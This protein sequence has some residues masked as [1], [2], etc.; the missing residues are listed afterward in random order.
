M[1][2]SVLFLFLLLSTGIAF[3]QTTITLQDQCNC[4]VLSGT[5]VSS[6]GALVPSGADT[7]DIYVNTNTGTIYFWDGNSWELTATDDQQLTGF[8][9]N[10]ATN[11]LTLT[12]EDGGSVNVD[13]SS[14]SDSLIDTNTT[15]AS[16]GIDGANTNLVITDSDTNTYAVALADIAALIDTDDQTLSEVLSEGNS[17][18]TSI[19]NVTDP[20]NA[21]DA[22]TKNY[23]D[24][25]ITANEADGSETIVNGGT[26]I[27]V[28]GSGT[29]G[30]PYIVN[31]TFTEVDGSIT[32]EIQDLASVL[33]E[34]NS[35]GTSITN[36]TDPTNAQDAATKNYVDTQ[37]T[38]NA[39][40]GSETIVNGGTDISV[41]GSGTTGDPYVVNNTFTEV[42][43]SITNE[44]NT[45]FEVSGANLEIEDGNGTLQVPLAN[46]GSDD[47]TLSEVLSEGNSAG[48][49]ITNV[50]DPTNAQDAA[51]KNYVDSQI[52]ANAADGSE[53]IVNGGTDI[54][55][56]GSGTTGDPYVVNNTFTEVDGSVTNEINTR[57]EV[58]GANLEIEDGN[59]T[60]QVPLANLG[61]DDQTLSEVLSEGNSAGT[62]ITNVTDPT[63]AQDAATKNYVDTQITANAA[64]GS[65]TI[66]NGG[67]DIS[68]SGSG[69]TGD[70]YIVNNTFTEVD[71]SITNEIQDL[72]SVLGEG[73]SAGTS[74]TNVTDP[75]NAQDA[76]TKNYVDTQI[77]ANA[78]DGSETIVNGGTDISVSGSG[79]TGDPYVV[80]NTFT[81]V[82]GSI[83]NEI[84]DLAS[85]LGE[86][87]SAGTSIT[88]VTDPTNAQDAATKNYVDSQITAN[89]ADGSE[90]IVNAGTDISVSGSGTT[91]D[92]YVVNNTFTEVDGSVTNEINTRFEVSGAN[93]EIED[94]NGTL[95]VPLANLGSD[96]QTLS[97]VLSEGNSAGTSITN[98]TDPTN[99]QDAATK[100]YVDS[101]ITANA[102]DGSE[103][104]VNGGT[105]ISV[106]GS[107]TTGDPYIVNSTFTEVDGSITN[108]MQ[109]LASVL[110]EGNSAGTSITN[111][112]DPTNAQDAAT[113]NYVDTQITANAADGSETIVNGGT[114][115]SVSG[116]G[117]T[118]DSTFTEVDGSVTNEINTR[119]DG[120]W[121]EP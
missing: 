104:I 55:V 54:S 17:A 59:G 4:E 66:V 80:N 68:V 91:G 96:D 79:T 89:A 24:T 19:T 86:G 45:R 117:T 97:E 111:V 85:V 61:S 23:V 8:T 47:Q 42:D 119:F 95:Q 82:D 43:G 13:L 1:K 63:N 118:G 26:D 101:Q 21:Q 27:S 105:D 114:D 37:I 51:T 41:S 74:I 121:G 20:T 103:T 34:G 48:T 69:T 65:E 40:D 62:S 106:S 36:V 72:A 12:L 39:A 22:A 31:S 109:D 18:G 75:T 120:K 100:N 67:T 115:I 52:T 16:F 15:I 35:A 10:D 64:D 49:S 28:S 77:T 56:S 29:T 11:T 30:D 33:G 108:E 9:F 81:E 112:T 99:A 3:S 44:V 46:L 6:P 107:G 2:K 57:F 73:N 113:K 5:D 70:P 88:N 110:G 116:S 94:G 50:T 102:A 92:P 38:A 58:S 83:T 53:T 7:G 87:N 90:T 78:A 84:Q 32:N 93:L 14:L 76:A 25:Q 60:L 71:G 98:V